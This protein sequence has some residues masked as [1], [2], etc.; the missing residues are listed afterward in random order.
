MRRLFFITVLLA[1]SLVNAKNST[2]PVVYYTPETSLAGGVI[3]LQNFG[4]IQDGRSSGIRYIGVYTAKS[5]SILIVRPNFWFQ[6]GRFNLFS[7]FIYE[8]FPNRYFETGNKTDRLEFEEFSE[9]SEIQ[10]VEGSWQAIENIYLHLG[11][12][13][14]VRNLYKVEAGKILDQLIQENSDLKSYTLQGF[15]GG[16]SWDDR[17]LLRY[18]SEG[19]FYKLT[20][21]DYNHRSYDFG[22]WDLDLRQYWT[23]G[24]NLVAALQFGLARL[25]GS[26]K[27][28]PFRS[29]LELGGKRVLRGFYSGRFKDLARGFLQIELRKKWNNWG[30]SVFA[31]LGKVA[32]SLAALDSAEDHSGLGFGGHYF[33]GEDG[34]SIRLDVGVAESKPSVYFVLDQAF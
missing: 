34:T 18:P 9:R 8:D 27:S 25:D 5:Q 15:G 11:Y 28:V 1:A 7:E 24:E 22:Q 3:Y 2:I 19:G 29:L 4:E 21:W 12:A 10:K 23:M 6:E 16:V 32:P 13:R 31:A 33:I 14:A 17:D 30:A 26:E 20:Y